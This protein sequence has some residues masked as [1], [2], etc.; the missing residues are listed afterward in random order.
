MY[1]QKEEGGKSSLHPLSLARIIR[2]V[3]VRPLSGFRGVQ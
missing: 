1:R 3:F 2:F